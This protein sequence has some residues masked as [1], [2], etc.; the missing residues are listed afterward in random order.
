MV[1]QLTSGSGR[2]NPRKVSRYHLTRRLGGPWSR[3]GLYG[4]EIKMSASTRTR[5]ARTV[6]F[7]DLDCHILA[8]GAMTQVVSRC[9]STRC[10]GFECRSVD[11]GSLVA[12]VALGEDSLLVLRCIW[13]LGF[14]EGRGGETWDHS[15]KIKLFLLSRNIRKKNTFTMFIGLQKLHKECSWEKRWVVNSGN[16]Q[17]NCMA[18]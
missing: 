7:V 12:N 18:S 11:V 16:K 8:G 6:Q 2:C 4:E 14:S 13:I 17:T 10:T 15:N 1:N 3:Y 5:A 9:L